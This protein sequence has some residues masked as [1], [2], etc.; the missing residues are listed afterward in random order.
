MR[1]NE[2]WIEHYGKEIGI[3]ILMFHVHGLCPQN[4]KR[5]FF[6]YFLWNIAEHFT[7]K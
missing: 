6:P 5:K 4:L 2:G 7:G 1:L 3:Y